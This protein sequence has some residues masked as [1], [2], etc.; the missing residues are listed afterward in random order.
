MKADNGIF[1][2]L[3]DVIVSPCVCYERHE[4]ILIAA[5]VRGRYMTPWSVY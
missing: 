3:F 4:N 2:T 5:L 1:E